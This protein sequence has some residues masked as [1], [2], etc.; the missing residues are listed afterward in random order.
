MAVDKLLRLPSRD[1]ALVCA[2]CRRYP[3]AVTEAKEEILL[4]P[5]RYDTDKIQTG[6]GDPTAAA[7]LRRERLLAFIDEI[8]GAAR[9]TGGWAWAVV[10][11]VCYQQRWDSI[12]PAKMPSG[13]RTEFFRA[14]RVFL[15][16]VAGILQEKGVM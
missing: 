11:N 5:I 4:S 10:Q 1:Y 8:N 3:L 2:Y 14:R 6:P 12:P 13:N 15:W 16:A 7:A 9:R